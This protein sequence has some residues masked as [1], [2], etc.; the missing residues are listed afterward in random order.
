M[1]CFGLT[2]SYDYADMSISWAFEGWPIH[3]IQRFCCFASRK[4]GNFIP[5]LSVGQKR[6]L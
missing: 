6:Q 5:T 3:Q 4:N 1:Y 2:A